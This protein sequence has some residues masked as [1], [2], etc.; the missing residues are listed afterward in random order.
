[1]FIVNLWL[2]FQ[3]HQ[4]PEKSRMLKKNK[5]LI[6]KYFLNL[7]NSAFLI[8]GLLFVGFGACLLLDRNTFL[9]ALDENKQFI[10]YIS[11]ILIGM[12]SA[13][14]LLCLLGYLSIHIKI[15]WLLILYAVVLSLAFGVQVVFSALIFTKK[16]EV[17][18]LWH[19]KMDLVISEYGSKDKPEDIPKWTIL[20]ALQKTCCGQHNYTDWI[21]NK[22][23]ETS[24][25]VPCS[26]TNSTL[27][28]WFCD[29]P[30]NATYLEGCGGKISTWFDANALTFIG[31][32][33]G[34]LTSE[35]L[36]VS[37]IVAFLRHKNRVYA[38]T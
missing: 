30:L 15:V 21:K 10:I 12:G 7:I 18:Q 22:N 33:F 26:C 31:I 20:N 37:F 2:S 35:V 1:M 36:Q 17:Q 34:L 3:I 23:K 19:D 16:E 4:F 11:Q 28:K 29:E 32:N 14:V 8:L 27:R 25:Q 6:F 24:D 9:T 38:E 13:V 5:E